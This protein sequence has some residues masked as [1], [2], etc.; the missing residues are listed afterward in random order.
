MFDFVQQLR[1]ALADHHL[2]KLDSAQVDAA[3]KD[4]AYSVAAALGRSRAALQAL[5]PD[6]AGT[7][8]APMAIAAAEHARWLVAQL[9]SRFTEL[10]GT[11]AFETGDEFADEDARCSIVLT[12]HEL[13][14]ATNAIQEADD[15][16][17]ADH[18]CPAPLTDQLT[19]LIEEMAALDAML[20]QHADE[21]APAAEFPLLRNLRA[22]VR[23]A[24]QTPPWWLEGT[25]EAAAERK[26]VAFLKTLP[27]PKLIE[28]RVQAGASQPTE[29]SRRR[30]PELMSVSSFFDRL[31]EWMAE[32]F[33]ALSLQASYV[34][35][36]TSEVVKTFPRAT[37]DAY[38]AQLVQDALG[39]WFLR[40]FTKDI[41]AAKLKLRLEVEP[42][43]PEMQFTAVAPAMFFAEVRLSENMANALRSGHRPVFRP[44]E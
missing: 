34:D 10:M 31:S 3:T 26:I 30:R 43:A 41:E 17:A 23:D 16:L 22:S 14:A 1:E 8:D 9:K 13:W 24:G 4:A 33:P 7:L 5:P 39:R 27:D 18:E 37:T 19:L 20:I 28:R 21:L 11:S 40:V 29:A 36:K 44:T 25:I 32:L 15:A 12:R 42:E 35:R 38:E 2:Q 6:L